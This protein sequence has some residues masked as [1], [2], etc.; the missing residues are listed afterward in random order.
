MRG[1]IQTATINFLT[2]G[3]YAR[4]YRQQGAD[5]AFTAGLL[6]LP[7]TDRQYFQCRQLARANSVEISFGESEI[8]NADHPNTVQLTLK[9]RKSPPLIIQARSVGGGMIEITRLQN[10]PVHLN[11]KQHDLVLFG[12]PEALET[13][14]SYF[15][16]HHPDWIKQTATP[17]AATQQLGL[18]DAPQ[19]ADLTFL[20]QLAGIECIW[21]I[22]PLFKIK[23]G[24]SLFLD[25]ETL[26]TLAENEGWSLGQAALAG[27]SSLLGISREEAFSE[28]DHRLRIMEE[29]ILHGLDNRGAN[30]QLL[31]PSAGNIMACEEA[32]DLAIGGLHSRA[33]A[34]AMAVMHSTN[35]AGVVCAAP[36]GGSAGTIPGIIISLAEALN[37]KREKMVMGLFAAGAIGTI[38]ARRATFAAEVAGCQVEIGAATAMG[39]AATI[40]MTGGGV[41]QAV[42]AAAI[43]LQNTMGSVCDLVQGICEIPCHTRNAIGASSALV[44][45]D[46][47]RGGYL[48]PIPL[49]E[50]IDAVYSVGRMLPP[51]LRCTALGGLAVTPTAKKMNPPGAMTRDV[52]KKE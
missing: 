50:T 36:T 37:I 6:G 12:R 47:I 27:E 26:I 15:C 30:M 45:A 11:G 17:E 38:I 33:A 20:E 44:C 49:D 8:S 14:K 34:R 41:R 46:L 31:S 24:P 35:S 28:M 32:G 5:L 9:G 16:T 2:N 40:E 19:T 52:N 23:K 4:V 48:N 18:S 39:A 29:S 3:S 10:R 7:L 21:Y 25:G 43:S 42:D 13:V 22:P 1:D 51:E